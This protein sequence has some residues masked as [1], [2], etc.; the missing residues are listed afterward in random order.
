MP[1]LNAPIPGRI[2]F[3][4]FKISSGVLIHDALALTLFSALT[5]LCRLLIPKLITPILKL[6]FFDF[7]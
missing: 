6:F 7:Y 4:E 5:T 2:I 1:S 3:S